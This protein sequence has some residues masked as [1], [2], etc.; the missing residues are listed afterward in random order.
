MDEDDL[1][2]V[3]ETIGR[4]RNRSIEV[5]LLMD[6]DDDNNDDN[7]TTKSWTLLVGKK[8]FCGILGMQ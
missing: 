8:K 4:G 1:K 3:E 7:D 2:S 5:Y 6:D